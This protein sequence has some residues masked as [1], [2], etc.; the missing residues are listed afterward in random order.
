M[1]DALLFQLS[2]DGEDFS[3]RAAIKRE[4]ACMQQMMEPFK[5][6]EPE[7]EETIMEIWKE[8]LEEINR[9]WQDE[10]SN[11]KEMDT[12]NSRMLREEC[13]RLKALA[14]PYADKKEELA[15]EIS[16]SIVR[17]E[18]AVGGETLHRG[19]YYPSPVYDI[20]V[21]NVH[22]GNVLKRVTSRS[23]VIWRY[24]FEKHPGDM[25]RTF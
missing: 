21:G 24:G 16:D 25:S 2:E 4:R 5:K 1:E 14:A 17:E 7:T 19:F 11:P 22:R 9:T 8:A 13:E 20:V 15:R 12:E 3:F 23:K 6:K 10:F 18:Q